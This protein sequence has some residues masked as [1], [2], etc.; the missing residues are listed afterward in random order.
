MVRNLALMLTPKCQ[1]I[2]YLAPLECHSF[3]T[4]DSEMGILMGSPPHP[5]LLCFNQGQGLLTCFIYADLLNCMVS[6]HQYK[7]PI[8]V[9]QMW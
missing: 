3:Q 8:K 5:S 2:N 7:Q 9:T 4:I 1:L 6:Q